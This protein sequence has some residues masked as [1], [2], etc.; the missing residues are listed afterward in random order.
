M[1]SIRLGSRCGACATDVQAVCVCMPPAI[2]SHRVI[3]THDQICLQRSTDSLAHHNSHT[4]ALISTDGRIFPR[5]S[6]LYQLSCGEWGALL[7]YQEFAEYKMMLWPYPHRRVLG[8]F[9]MTARGVYNNPRQACLIS[10]KDH[11][12]YPFVR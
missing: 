5:Y 3:V 11:F 2:T 12:C 10:C 1:P 6:S 7:G 8:A 4:R 9:C